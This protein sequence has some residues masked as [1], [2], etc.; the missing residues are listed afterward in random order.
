MYLL[1]FFFNFWNTINTATNDRVDGGLAN[2]ECPLVRGVLPESLEKE[3][4]EK[5]VKIY[6]RLSCSFKFVMTNARDTR[7]RREGGEGDAAAAVLFFFSRARLLFRKKNASWKRDLMPKIF[8]I[9]Y[10]NNCNI[11]LFSRQTLMVC[12]LFFEFPA[13]YLQSL[14]SFV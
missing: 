9:F 11:F 10:F 2:T 8:R 7:L 6:T 3:E 13:N 1:L 12:W 14:F 4:D 5:H